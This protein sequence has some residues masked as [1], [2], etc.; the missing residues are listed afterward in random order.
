MELQT[1]P[2]LRNANLSDYVRHV[3]TRIRQTIM[4]AIMMT[5]KMSSIRAGLGLF[6]PVRQA[7]MHA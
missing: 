4:I 3:P 7:C 1:E 2:A 5:R 6:S